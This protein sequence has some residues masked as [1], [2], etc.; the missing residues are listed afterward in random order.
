V[1]VE[2]AR[3]DHAILKLKCLSARFIKLLYLQFCK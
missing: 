3:Q 2:H 1:D